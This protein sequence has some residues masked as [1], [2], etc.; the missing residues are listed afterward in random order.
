[1]AS[2]G[3]AG[4]SAGRGS[5]ATVRSARNEA[6]GARH[7]GRR[8][9]LP[10]PSDRLPRSVPALACPPLRSPSRFLGQRRCSKLGLHAW[11]RGHH[12][13]VVEGLFHA[14]GVLVRIRNPGRR[15]SEHRFVKESYGEPVEEPP[16]GLEFSCGCLPF[17]GASFFYY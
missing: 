2:P 5:V 11:L 4:F 13:S 8:H 6:C 10:T 17:Y 15:Y 14:V 7:L 1:M 12:G 9:H 16:G 3:S